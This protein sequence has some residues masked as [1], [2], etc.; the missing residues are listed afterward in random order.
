M[1]WDPMVYARFGEER[2][3][4]FLELVDRVLAALPAEQHADFE[5]EYAAALRRAYPSVDGRTFFEF[6]RIF[7]VGH[8]AELRGTLPTAGAM[9]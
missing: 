6:R 4:P 8:R 1:V 5:A 7:A 9:E 2:L 3:R